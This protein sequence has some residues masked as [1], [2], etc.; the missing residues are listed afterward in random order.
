[1]PDQHQLCLVPLVSG[2]D[3]Q[4]SNFWTPHT[5]RLKPLSG[6]I[7]S[8]QTIDQV[9]HVGQGMVSVVSCPNCFS[10]MYQDRMTFTGTKLMPS[11]QYKLFF[12]SNSPWLIQGRL[13]FG[14]FYFFLLFLP[15]LEG[16][17]DESDVKDPDKNVCPS[18][19]LKYYR[20]WPSDRESF[21]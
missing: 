20:P 11:S 2:A 21:V 19:S 5:S 17:I 12:T 8:H 9:C 3:K 1:M 18:D 6:M 4:C 10:C 13:E 15:L 16:Y 7:R 14:T